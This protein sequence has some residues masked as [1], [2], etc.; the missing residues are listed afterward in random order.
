MKK[1]SRFS[2]TL[3]QKL[4]FGF[5]MTSL[6]TV[7]VGGQGY[8]S[9]SKSLKEISD[10]QKDDLS[11]L[12][13][14]ENL[15]T[16]A[17]THRRYEK[18]FFL[19]IGNQKKQNEYLEKFE[20]VSSA[21]STLL[22][23]VVSQ[24][25]SDPHYSDDVR[26]GIELSSSSY[27]NYR[28]GFLALTTQVG[29]DPEITPQKANKLME[30]IKN[31]IYNFEN[32]IEVLVDETEHMIAEVTS[33][34]VVQN[35][36]AKE[37]IMIFII[38]G[39]LF[40][41]IV[42]LLI[43]RAIII[44][45]SEAVNF[46]ETLAKGD[47]STSLKVKNQDEI[48]RLI[49]SLNHMADQLSETLKGVVDGVM[50][51]NLSSTELAKISEYFTKEAGNTSSRSESVASSAE[52]M[53]SNL[54]AVAAAMEQSATNVT[55]VASA[56]E[57]MSATISEIAA[58]ANSARNISGDAVKQAESASEFMASLGRAAKEINNVTETIT[59][60]SEQTNLLALNAT[61]EAARAGEAGKGFA[62][63]AN[64]I[65][66][67]AKQTAAATMDIK[68]KINDVQSTTD[69]TVSQINSV[70]RVIDE[71]NEIIN[72]IA[73]AVDEQSNATREISANVSQASEGIQ[74]VNENVSQSSAASQSITSEIVEVSNS[75]EH[76][77][78]ES[79]TVKNSANDLSKLAEELNYLVSRFSFG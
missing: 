70:S 4:I 63:V 77:R 68:A 62:V 55:M 3:R 15:K 26:K 22:K 53:T 48:G 17:L 41:A 46:S 36:R 79:D 1:S 24:V 76:M 30:P 32:G 66:E 7:F 42:G 51:L 73:I 10:M 13:K 2:F 65:K 20:K 54:N 47:F 12:V 75:A 43:S 6:I 28:S 38:I 56:T 44:P 61:I 52:E 59:E 21:T 31:E 18:D 39:V 60:I 5:L 8:W 35:S 27:G 67:L 40:S 57:E 33:T 16:M 50:T 11:L 49:T 58:K 71:I 23:E 34:I 14:V 69:T 9:S 74:E 37:I 19:N 78:Q 64:E 25:A 29:S 72:G 45:L